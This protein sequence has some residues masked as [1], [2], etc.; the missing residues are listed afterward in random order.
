ML[1]ETNLLVISA[2]PYF[3]VEPKIERKAEG[4]T[5]VFKCEASGKPEPRIY[6]IYNGSPISLAAHKE[7]RK[8]QD[9]TI[10]IFNLTNKDTGNYGCNATNGHGYVYKDVYVN[11][12]GKEII[13]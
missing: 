13:S 6:W 10:E 12:L 9:N 3:T 7:N 4:E 8:I 2:I 5:A 11:V 1:G